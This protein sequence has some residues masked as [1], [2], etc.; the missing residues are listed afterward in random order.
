VANPVYFFRKPTAKTSDI[1][2]DFLFGRLSAN[3][4]VASTVQN[5]KLK[6]RLT[7]REKKSSRPT[8]A[9]RSPNIKTKKPSRPQTAV[10]RDT[11]DNYVADIP[12]VEGD[13]EE[14]YQTL[15][16]QLIDCIIKH[17]IYT[18]KDL[19]GLFNRT[20]VRNQHLQ[21]EKMWDVFKN[22]KDEFDREMD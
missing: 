6:K 11:F 17:R 13:D 16:M 21:T 7:K 22:I 9:H 4:R 18:D 20:V 1:N 19:E 3:T 15:Q 14:A 12:T 5:K 8:T 2:L 10:H